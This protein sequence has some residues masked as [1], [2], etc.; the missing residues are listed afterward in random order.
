MASKTK[1]KNKAP[2]E[3]QITAEQLLREAKER[4]LEVSKA[5]NFFLVINQILISFYFHFQ[6]Q[7][8]PPAPKQK[9]SD[10]EE[11]DAYRLKK[12]K[13][14]EDSIRKNRLVLPNWIKYAEFEDSQHEIERSRSVFERCLDVH[15]RNPTVWLRYA[16]MEIRNRQTNHARNIFDRAVKLMPR[17]GQFWYKY[18]YFEEILGNIAGARHVF[19]RWMEWEPEQQA[20]QTYI[21]FELRYKEIERARKIHARFVSVHPEVKNWL[22]F[23]RFEEKNGFI[24]NAREVF[25]KAIEFFGD[26]HLDEQLFMQFAKFEENQKELDRARV[27]YKYALEKL[28]KEKCVE[29]FKQF[30]L[31]EKR[32]GDRTGIESIVIRKRKTKYEEELKENPLN[33]DTWFDYIRLMENE[34]SEDA[35]Q[36]RII[37]ERAVANIPPSMTEKRLW[38]RYIYLWIYYAIFE[39]LKVK[40]IERAREVYQFCLKL[41][42]HKQF[43]FAK[44]WI[45]AAKFEIRQKDLTAARK[46]LGTAIG[47]CPKDK[48]FREYI[49]LEIQLREFERCRVLYEKFIEFSSE[50]CT[51]WIKYAEL[52]SILGEIDRARAIYEIAI[53]QP[54]LDMPEIVWKS[55]VDFEIEQNEYDRARILY[56]RLLEKTQHVK[57]WISFA[58][59]ELDCFSVEQARR[60]FERANKSMQDANQ[61]AETRLMLLEAWL[62][63][64]QSH[65][66]EKHKQHVSSLMPNKVKKRRKTENDEWIEYFEYYFPSDKTNNLSN[67]LANVKKLVLILL[68]SNL[69]INKIFS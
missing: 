52:E 18:T 28:P 60:V 19:E 14:F 44:I 53:D 38:R 23:A 16:E 40:N 46:L 64:E 66:E 12:R 32:Y 21:N 10:P 17:C 58:K 9:I 67:L 65:G 1:V 57:V 61:D 3:I 25:E 36:I 24:E 33:Y 69:I 47:V 4:E 27:I 2:A 45:L 59:F 6:K 68:L 62:E 34:E 26:D 11:L 15:N 54:R 31:F 41:I 29:L 7:I 42:P 13:Q 8:L 49:E 20:F 63:F 55:F 37:Y 35:E 22:K 50:N 30:T 51:T 48:L 5:E 56:E 43:T 39:E